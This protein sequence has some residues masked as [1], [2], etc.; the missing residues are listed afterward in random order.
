MDL[1]R[2]VK[3]EVA[4]VLNHTKAS[5]RMK[6]EVL[7]GKDTERHPLGETLH[8]LALGVGA[9]DLTD[10]ENMESLMTNVKDF[11]PDATAFMTPGDRNA[12]AAKEREVQNRIDDDAQYDN[13][14]R[15]GVIIESHMKTDSANG[16]NT[17]LILLAV[18]VMFLA[19]YGK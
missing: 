13:A 19:M 11:E 12:L 4:D 1:T 5:K 9:P 14:D 2:G 3:A 6:W 10:P 15:Y 17:M 7:K 8:D 18:G 16:G